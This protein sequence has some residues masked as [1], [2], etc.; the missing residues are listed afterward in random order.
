MAKI[1]VINMAIITSGEKLIAECISFSKVRENTQLM[2]AIKS[3]CSM[4]I[5]TEST[6]LVNLSIS[7]IETPKL[8]ADIN[9]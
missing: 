6:L 1:P 3:I 9:V 4:A 2:T 7:I 8:I 5:K